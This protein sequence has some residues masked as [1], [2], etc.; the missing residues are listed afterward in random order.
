MGY[1]IPKT[2]LRSPARGGTMLQAPA[3]QTVEAT[4]APAAERQLPVAVGF[5]PR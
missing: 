4:V 3:A 5:N 1:A 2:H